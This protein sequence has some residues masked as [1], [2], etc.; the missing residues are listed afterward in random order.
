MSLRQNAGFSF[1]VCSYIKE[2]MLKNSEIAGPEAVF[3]PMP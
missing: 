3:G 1:Q 2:A